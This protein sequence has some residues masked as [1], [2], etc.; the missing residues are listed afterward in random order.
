[1]ALLRC[2]AVTLVLFAALPATAHGTTV[3]RNA[4]AGFITVE[5]SA[6]VVDAI[7]V[8][9]VGGNHVFT[10]NPGSL[11]AGSGCMANAAGSEV[12][13]T[14]AGTSIAVDLGAG[15]DSFKADGLSVPIS[16]AGGVGNDKLSG[17]SRNDVLAGGEGID[18]LTGHGGVDDYFGEGGD[19]TIEARD[20]AAER[21]SCGAGDDRAFNDFIDIIAEC[22]RGIDGD[23]DGFSSAVDCNDSAARIFSG[24]PEVFENGVDED[25][26]GRDNVD[27]DRDGDGFVR[28]IDCDD[29]NAGI[30]P[31]ARE[32]RGNKVDENCDN[33]AAPF[34]Q[35]AT[36]VSNRWVVAG[37][38]TRLLALVVR[39]APKGAKIVL[40]CEGA[41]CPIDRPR[42]RTVRRNLK[43]VVLHKGFKRARLRPGAELRLSITAPET[44]GRIYTFEVERGALPDSRIVC[45]PPGKK[46][47]RC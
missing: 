24:A 31:N 28:P 38:I 8:T 43:K 34:A 46:G 9:T 2:I 14:P 30:R 3:Q 23:N 22:E 25:C 35:L 7:A 20:G 4:Q 11:T 26:D 1:L 40:R 36:V 19:D 15:D 6:T 41:G 29:G 42:R 27:L 17:G 44:I 32:I 21:I 37:G 45:R 10:S 5:D 47:R 18:E 16:V 12:T 13:C 33:R 39:N